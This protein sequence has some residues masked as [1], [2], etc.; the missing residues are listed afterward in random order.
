LEPLQ[1]AKWVHT[2]RYNTY[3][4]E[5]ITHDDLNALETKLLERIERTETT[6]LREFR[7][8]AVSFETRF[9]VNEIL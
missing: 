9:R 1:A 8:W 4:S 7:K 3:V 2:W 5:P 6:L